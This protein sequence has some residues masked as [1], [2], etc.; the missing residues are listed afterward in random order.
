MPWVVPDYETRS[1]CDLK[2]AGSRRYAEDPTTSILCLVVEFHDGAAGL[3]E[4]AKVS[5]VPGQPC[6]PEVKAAIADPSC[7]WVAHNAGFEKDI[8]REI[9]MPVFGWPELPNTRWHCTQ[10]MAAMRVIPQDLEMAAKVMRLPVSKDMDGNKLTLSMSKIDKK[11][12]Y[13]PVLTPEKQARI[14][15]YCGVDVETQGHLHKRLGWMPHAERQVW[16]LNQRV[17]ERGIRLDMGLVAAMRAVVDTASPP[18]EEEFRGLTGGLNMTQIAKVGAWAHGRGVHLD[19]LNK[20][21]LAEALGDPED[22]EYDPADWTPEVTGMDPVVH[23]ALTIRRLIG[24]ASIKKLERMEAC[25]CADGRVR[26]TFQYHGT[27]PGRSAGRLFQP[28]NF[29]RGSN[30]MLALDVDTKVD[31]LM[32]R[33]VDFIEMVMGPAVES[34]VASLRHVL[35][36]GPGRVYVSG[37]FSGIQ[38]RTVLGIAGQHDKTALMAAGADVYCDMAGQVYKRVITKKDTAERTIGKNCVLGLGFQMGAPK[39]RNKYARESTLEFIEEVVRIYREEWAPGVPKVWRNL[40]DCALEAVKTGRPVETDYGVEYRRED[41]W[42]TA[43]LPSGR[44]LWYF[45]PQ[46]VRRLMPW[47]TEDEPDYRLGWTYQAKKMGKWLTIDAFGG[48]LT[49]NVVMG[50]ERD[51]MTHAMFALEENGFPVV[52]EVH[53]EIVAEPLEVDAD[54]KAFQQIMT[55]VPDW[56]KQIGIPVAVEGWM[57]ARYRK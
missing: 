46:L 14:V 10:A 54:E 27:G 5:W 55:D 49:E 26:R 41:E 18:L 44:K 45:N 7:T 16:L 56:C 22:A 32:T 40:Q 20:E 34:V 36:P 38:A 1:F 9:Q 48:Q 57:G 24:S 3:P 30:A 31:T 50:I 11:T 25:V 21:S 15:E 47:S 37:D 6:P 12:G 4:G 53:D 42:L 8:W 13:A 33:D 19:G 28:H 43:R 23:R 35:V 39:F 52:L 2:V 17:N 51:L 29:P